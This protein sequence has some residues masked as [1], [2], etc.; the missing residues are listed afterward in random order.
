MAVSSSTFHVI[1]LQWV[2]IS[3]N[4]TVS[5]LKRN[6][7]I[8]NLL[9][10]IGVVRDMINSVCIYYMLKMTISIDHKEISKWN[11]LNLWTLIQINHSGQ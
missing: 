8:I 5:S 11:E 6:S 10:Q 3:F 7:A 2:Y 9:Q 4:L 1:E